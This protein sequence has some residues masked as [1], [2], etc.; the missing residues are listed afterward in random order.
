[1]Q[2][3]LFSYFTDPVLRAPTIG[4]MLMC[5]AAG[6]IGVIVFLRKESLVGESL[7][8]ATYPGVAL[9]A[10]LAALF[11]SEG[12]LMLS[13]GILAGSFLSA[14]FG[15]WLFLF[16]QRRFRV[17]GDAALCFV[18][19]AFFGVGITIASR[20]QFSHASLY[21]QVQTY[22]YGQAAT[23]TDIHIV[24]YGMLALAAAGAVA[25]FYKELMIIT[26]DRD[27]AKS[28]GIRVKSFDFLVFT[29]VVLAVV[30][31]IRSVGVVLMSAMLIAPAVS[32]RQ[33]SNRLS[34]VFIFA[35]VIGLISGFL[36]NLLSL[37]LSATLSKLY[38]HERVGV[39]TGPMIVIV[40][41]A[42]SM[43]ALLF[44]PKRGFV[45]R[46]IRA[47]LFRNRCI[48]E[49]L[50]KTMWKG[51]EG[52]LMEFEQVVQFQSGP[53]VYLRSMLHHLVRE[54][55]VAKTPEGY[56]LTREGFHRAARI[57][58]L[59]RLWEVYLVEYLGIGAEKVHRSA[60]EMEHILTPD[61]EKKLT[62]LLHDPS[63][64]PHH[65]PIPKEEL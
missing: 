46:R 39:P 65:Q 20:M 62:K 23:M 25:F 38:P 35:G 64:D 6:L 11:E 42:I 36:G 15:F 29:L 51:G 53:K 2:V 4:S 34:R 32:A 27:Y 17:P 14:S 8:H 50:L 19:S 37:E 31:G 40:A 30:I 21:R 10:L 16:L 24:I 61:L 33:F 52:A 12:S 58:R 26:L 43:L 7:S 60:E 22:L 59:H 28:L 49:N 13:F 56:S 5:F 54:G 55:W 45:I 63:Y 9:G 48:R 41:A 3:S 18:L 57:V 47:N 1:M 44:A